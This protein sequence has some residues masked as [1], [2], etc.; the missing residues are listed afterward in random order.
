MS[1]LAAVDALVSELTE[2]W[3]LP[4]E[5]RLASLHKEN[6]EGDRERLRAWAAKP[7]GAL[8]I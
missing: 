1:T 4:V 2:R 5:C 6:V 8:P 7:P 3:L